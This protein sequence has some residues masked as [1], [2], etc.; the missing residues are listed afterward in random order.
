MKKRKLVLSK[1][2]AKIID[3]FVKLCIKEEQISY[4]LNAARMGASKKA[5]ISLVDAYLD[6]KRFRLAIEA[7][8]LGIS[9]GALDRL[10][11]FFLSADSSFRNQEA[12]EIVEILEMAK[13]FG[14]KIPTSTANSLL[15]TFTE[16]EM[17]GSATVTARNFG[18]SREMVDF[19]VKTC[20]EKNW[21]I[22]REKPPSSLVHF[23][24]IEG[25]ILTDEEKE[26][27]TKFILGNNS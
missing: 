21:T 10:V 5:I 23:I 20:L 25:R 16:D 4:A 7:G 8:K 12:G 11:K 26:E 17:M 13:A 14:L 6:I 3:S 22:K 15:K 18:A 27:I 2:R 24:K 1:E 19:L 9:R